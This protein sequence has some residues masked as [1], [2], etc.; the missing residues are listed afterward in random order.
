MS[1]TKIIEIIKV[2]LGTLLSVFIMGAVLK[3][4]VNIFETGWNLF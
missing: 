4:I 1:K 3:I 2:V